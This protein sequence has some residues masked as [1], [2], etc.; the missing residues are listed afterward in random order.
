MTQEIATWHGALANIKGVYLVTDTVTGKLYVGKA[1]G[2]AGIWQR[3]CDYA[4][5]GHGG[6]KELIAVL[7][8]N[9]SDYMRNFQYSILEIAD[10]HASEEDILDRESHWMNVLKSR[11]YGMNSK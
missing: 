7:N 5:N 3:W 6:N 1:S 8:E 11:E 2:E 10:S 4:K 9:G